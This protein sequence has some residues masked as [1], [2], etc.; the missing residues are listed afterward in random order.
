MLPTTC[1]RFSLSRLLPVQIRGYR[2]LKKVL[3]IAALGSK[4]RLEL[5]LLLGL[6]PYRDLDAAV[7]FHGIASVS[8]PSS[9]AQVKKLA[10]HLDTA[11]FN[12]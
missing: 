11:V 12:C 5:P 4:E 8:S 9:I 6:N 7:F 10:I 2:F 1:L 3:D